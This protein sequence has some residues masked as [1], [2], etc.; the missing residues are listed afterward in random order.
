MPDTNLNMLQIVANGLG[1]LK[2]AGIQTHSSSLSTPL[3]V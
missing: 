1:E 3:N 2:Q